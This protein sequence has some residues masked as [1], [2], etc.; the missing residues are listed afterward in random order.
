MML[1]IVLLII[2]AGLAWLHFGLGLWQNALEAEKPTANA[3]RVAVKVGLEVLYAPGNAIRFPPPS[4]RRDPAAN[5]ERMDLAL[6]WPSLHGFNEELEPDFRDPSAQAPVLRLAVIAYDDPVSEEER[7][8]RV[9]ETNFAAAVDS[10]IAGL[11]A[12]RLAP[13]SGYG[14][15][16]LYESAKPGA[17]APDFYIRCSEQTGAAAPA[18]CFRRVRIATGLVM[19]YHYRRGLLPRWREIDLA[20]RRY[21]D[22]MRRGA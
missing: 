3:Q 1:L 7:Y 19:E 12:H 20:L 8:Q 6:H 5:F 17:A 4:L 22:A 14:G 13:G 21:V 18:S 9:F 10:G 15:E 16:I 11:T 2:G